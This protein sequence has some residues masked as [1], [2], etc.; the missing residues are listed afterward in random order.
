MLMKLVPGLYVLVA[1]ISF[2]C[3]VLVCCS[4]EIDPDQSL[5]EDKGVL[6]F[7]SGFEPGSKIA[8]GPNPFTSD[9]KIVGRDLSVSPPNHWVEDIDNSKNLGRISL[10]YQGADTTMRIARIIS[11]PGNPGNK[12]LQFRINEPWVNSKGSNLARIQVNIYKPDNIDL[13]GIKELYQTVRLFLHEDME[14][15][16]SYPNKISWLTIMEVW[17]N[18][19]WDDYPYPFRL[20]VGMGKPSSAIQGLFFKVDAEDYNYPTSTTKGGYVGIWNRMNTNVVIPIGKWMTLEYYI[21]EGN[22]IDGRFYMAMTPEGGKKQVIFDVQNFTHNT[23]DPSPDGI[24]SWNPLKLYTSRE[25]T[26]FVKGEGKALQVYWDDLAI[27]K[28]RFPQ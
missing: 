5:P 11:E 16:K 9:E 18:K 12:V 27:W 1:L 13:I 20:T 14:V 19:T 21:K 26:N 6:L 3:S 10:Q 25:L 4:K 2:S 8:H 15:L 28:N 24:T 23:K 22:N 7:N 17:N